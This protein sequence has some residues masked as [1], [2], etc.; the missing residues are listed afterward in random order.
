MRF[1][2]IALL[3]ACN[4]PAFPT[5][6]PGCHDNEHDCGNGACCLEG[7]T[8]GGPQVDA[9]ETCP[10]GMCCFEEPNPPAPRK[11]REQRRR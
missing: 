1:S 7:W 10:S 8:C 2:A 9:P 3:L 6:G 4:A 11:R 5:P